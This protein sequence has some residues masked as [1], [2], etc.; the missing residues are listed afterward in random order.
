MKY[1]LSSKPPLPLPDHSSAGYRKDLLSIALEFADEAFKERNSKRI[2][3]VK[4]SERTPEE[5]KYLAALQKQLSTALNVLYPLPMGMLDATQQQLQQLEEI[6]KDF[7]K[8]FSK[9]KE[10]T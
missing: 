10:N 1:D 3:L 5:E 7:S 9:K 2:E 4:K 8:N 6:S